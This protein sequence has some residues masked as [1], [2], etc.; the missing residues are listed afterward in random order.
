[1]SQCE[2]ALSCPGRVKRAPLRERNETP[3]SGLPE[4]GSQMRASR[5]KPDLRGPSVRLAKRIIVFDAARRVAL[6]PGS[7]S[8]TLAR[9]GHESSRRAISRHRSWHRL[10]AGRE[11]RRAASRAPN[12]VFHFLGGHFV[13]PLSKRACPERKAAQ[14]RGNHTQGLVFAFDSQLVDDSLEGEDVQVGLLNEATAF[15]WGHSTTI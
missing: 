3:I 4:I 10:R 13:A 5:V 1:M 12:S 11:V 14:V 6:G 9:P 7:R 15:V 2:I 8:L